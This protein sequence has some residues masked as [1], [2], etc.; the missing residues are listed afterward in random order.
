MTNLQKT[1]ISVDDRTN[2]ICQGF[3]IWASAY[4]LKPIT[5]DDVKRMWQFCEL[6]K[7]K[8]IYACRR[9]PQ[10]IIPKKIGSSST[11]TVEDKKKDNLPIVNYYHTYLLY[12]IIVIMV[13][14]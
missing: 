12:I 5:E 1:V 7:N 2:L 10:G 9:P 8:E 4:Y 11:H 6:W 14:C 13:M 3:R